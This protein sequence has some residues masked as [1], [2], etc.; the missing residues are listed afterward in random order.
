[1]AAAAGVLLLARWPRLLYS[2]VA[3]PLLVA[4]LLSYFPPVD[5]QAELARLLS[6]GGLSGRQEIW[7]RA[8]AALEDFSY[9]GIGLGLF[10]Q[11]TPALYPYD[12]LPGASYLHAHN[13]YLQVGLDL[14]MAGQIAYISLWILVAALLIDML[15]KPASPTIRTLTLGSLGASATLLANGLVDAAMWGTK[16]SFL[17]W[18]LFALVVQLSTAISCRC[19]CRRF[20]GE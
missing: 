8:L 1:M 7:V 2:L 3:A 14:G 10:G 9:T 12:L 17:P 19:F 13:V 16:L 11:V 18:M 4:G 15:R 6:I 20:C 5:V